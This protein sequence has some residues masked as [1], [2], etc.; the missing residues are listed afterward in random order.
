[1]SWVA[2]RWEDFTGIH[3]ARLLSAQQGG[4]W[5]SQARTVV[6]AL[7]GEFSNATEHCSA[8][9]FTLQ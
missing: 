1:M 8:W 9:Y 4:L 2:S 3:A 6:I 7:K 5:V